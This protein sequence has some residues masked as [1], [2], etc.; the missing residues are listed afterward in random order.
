MFSPTLLMILYASFQ[1]LF[2]YHYAISELKTD[3]GTCYYKLH[4]YLI[5][6]LLKTTIYKFETQLWI[7]IL[8]VLLMY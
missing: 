6:E 4:E 7:A 5:L 2:H 1:F 3:D 8:E